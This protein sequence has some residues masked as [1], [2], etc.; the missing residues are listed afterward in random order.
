MSCRYISVIRFEIDTL[1]FAL[2]EDIQIGVSDS[3]LH[4][5]TDKEPKWDTYVSKSK[6]GC[7][8]PKTN[9]IFKIDDVAILRLVKHVASF[10]YSD[11]TWEKSYKNYQYLNNL[12]AIMYKFGMQ[13]TEPSLMLIRYFLIDAWKY[14]KWQSCI[15]NATALIFSIDS[16]KSGFVEL[17]KLAIGENN[18]AR[19]QRNCSL[20][21]A[22]CERYLGH[23]TV[24]V[25]P[26][27]VN[28]R[29]HAKDADANITIFD[30]FIPY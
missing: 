3:R 22:K 17:K 1:F 16:I 9:Q 28:P 5:S 15:N 14:P 29:L 8:Q 23:I 6:F 30:V 24:Q 11:S 12:Q 20:Q 13:T 4:I 10:F 21:N 2:F 18:M 7:W 27:L 19:L 26:K 25:V